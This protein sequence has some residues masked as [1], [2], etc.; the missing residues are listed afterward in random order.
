MTSP[1]G[2][3]WT[4]RT[5][6]ED[7]SWSAV[8]WSSYLSLF[9]AVA[10]DGTNRVMTSSDGITWA[11]ASA[12]AANEWRDVI[13]VPELLIFVA[14][15]SSGTNDGVMTSVNGTTWTSRTTPTVGSGWRRVRWA[16]D[17]GYMVASASFHFNFIR[18]EDGVT[19]T[20][21]PVPAQ[22]SWYS[23][24]YS[25]YLQKFASAALSGSATDSVIFTS[26]NRYQVYCEVVKDLGG[27]NATTDWSE[28]SWSD[29]R[30]W[31]SSV[32]LTEGR[33]FWAGK[34]GIY[35][36]VSDDYYNFNPETEGDSAPI[37]RTIGIGPVDTINWLLPLQRLLIGA[38]GS[39]IVGRSSSFDEP[40]TRTNF[41]LRLATDQGSSRVEAV[42]I[43]RM[44]V[45]VQRG[46]T[47]IIQM[48]YDGGEFEF[49]AQDLTLLSPEVCQ[50]QVV[51]IAVQRQPDTRVHCVLSDGTVA[52]L[53]YDR[54]E[55]VK[56]WVKVETDG[57][58][59]DVVVL[60]GDDGDS[61]DKVYYVVNR[62]ISGS[63][64]RYLEKWAKESDCIGGTLNH[65]ADSYLSVSQA[66]ST[67]ITGLS[68][69]AGE[70]VSVWANGKNLGT[71]TVSG[72]A[73][74]V[75]EA[76]TTAIVGLGYTATWK[77]SKL[78]YGA[79][80]G[81][82]L[83]QKKTLKHLGVILQ[84]THYQGLEYGPDFTTMDNLPLTK[85]GAI[86]SADT[87]HSSYDQETFEFPGEWNTDSRLCLRAT[88]PKPCTILAA[89][90]GI[91]T[92]E[93]F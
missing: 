35:G 22:N 40:L 71:Y 2:I 58:V 11:T 86:I 8:C 64:F 23:L 85:N 92:N 88:A 52:I 15:A 6:A 91:E 70:T 19:W 90:M 87:V 61:E 7:N 45:F 48:V 65:Q 5:S 72:G 78:A 3:T 93:K 76:V 67:T 81:T 46:G 74:T 36:S 44:G 84:N 53:I 4:S 24:T 56:C 33:L 79:R 34:N 55:D 43:D 17:L 82:A 14:V 62:T 21:T 12:A 68:H 80:Q 75:S 26:S 49:N 83:L 32:T 39:E 59:E 57:T 50:P 89:V 54:A 51:R 29:Y 69:L 77:S 9:V 30:G 31:P 73:I 13:W 10:T 25:P 66:S 18:S 42:R 63:T 41:N 20:S 60:P 47:R 38:E 27:T 28:G 37:N 1:D 16:A